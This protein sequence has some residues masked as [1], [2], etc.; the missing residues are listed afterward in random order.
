MKTALITGA[1][2]GIGEAF[3]DIFA[4][5]GFNIVLVARNGQKMNSI[6]KTLTEKTTVHHT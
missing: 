6:C 4:K 5:N 3:A 2:S 1:S